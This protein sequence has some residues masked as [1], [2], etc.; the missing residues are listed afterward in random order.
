MTNSSISSR[1][2]LVRRGLTSSA[3]AA[4]ASISLALPALAHH[5][6][7]GETPQTLW[8]GIFSGIAHPVLGVDH[9]VF[10]I[11][12]GLLAAVVRCGVLVPAAFLMAALVG[13]GLHLG[14]L[15]LPAAEI[16][17][18]G[19]VGLF[20]LLV[21]AHERLSVGAIAALSGIAGLFH[22]YAYGEAIVGS[23][24]TPLVAYLIGF[25]LVQAAI[26][27]L[28]YLVASRASNIVTIRHAGFAI[29]GAGAALLSG[30]VL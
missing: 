23:E 25:T 16:V 15:D 26:A 10:V 9:F 7:G 20:G 5:P 11:A 29:F 17:I 6:F 21:T 22:G 14:A 30:L 3:I 12:L 2:A 24:P 4:I 18:A 1:S 13:T 8:A 27:F 19:S 28:A